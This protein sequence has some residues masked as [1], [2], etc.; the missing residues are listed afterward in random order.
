MSSYKNFQSDNM[1]HDKDRYDIYNPEF[2]SSVDAKG[3]KE[4]DNFTKNL[5]KYKKFVQWSR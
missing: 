4:L 1:K 2:T 5:H 3:E